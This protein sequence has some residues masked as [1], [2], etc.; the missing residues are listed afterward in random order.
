MVLS[1]PTSF[2]KCGQQELWGCLGKS[3]II[4][5]AL[6]KMWSC[7][8]SVECG[9]PQSPNSHRSRKQQGQLMGRIQKDL[10][11]VLGCSCLFH[12]LSLALNLRCHLAPYEEAHAIKNAETHN[13]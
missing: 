13:V 8:L 5:E 9:W 11:L 2:G 3:S 12:L 7:F 10:A 6:P 1:H 4:F